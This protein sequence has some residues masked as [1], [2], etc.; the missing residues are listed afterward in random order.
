MYCPVLPRKYLVSPVQ[1]LYIYYD[2]Q[3]GCSLPPKWVLIPVKIIIQ[4]L[5]I[6]FNTPKGN[7]PTIRKDLNMICETLRKEKKKLSFF[8]FTYLQQRNPN[9]LAFLVCFLRLGTYTLFAQL[10]WHNQYIYIKS[11][12][13]EEIN[14]CIFLFLVSIHFT[15][16]QKWLM[17][18]VAGSG[19]NGKHIYHCSEAVFFSKSL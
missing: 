19:L 18:I 17:S 9:L 8:F 5:R 7:F 15:M 2:R 16:I 11:I 4:L 12:L 10:T 6:E 3:K 1:F 13:Q 14:L